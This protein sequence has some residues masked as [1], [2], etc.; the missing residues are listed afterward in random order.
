MIST[1][2][3]SR[4]SDKFFI[5]SQYYHTIIVRASCRHKSAWIC[6]SW[7]SR[8]ILRQSH[9]L[10]N[11]YRRSVVRLWLCCRKLIVCIEACVTASIYSVTIA[12]D[13]EIASSRVGRKKSQRIYDHTQEGTPDVNI[14]QFFTSGS[15][16]WIT[17]GCYTAGA[18]M[19]LSRQ[20]RCLMEAAETD[21]SIEYSWELKANP[22]L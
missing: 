17:I 7:W 18:L 11:D 2:D 3:S 19:L 22:T 14:F 9:H 12:A 5:M 13:H 10:S 15:F 16:T 21:A 4:L 8:T 6:V 1:T 20:T